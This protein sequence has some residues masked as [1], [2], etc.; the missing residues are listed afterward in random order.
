[1]V[2]F[3]R[4][5]YVYQRVPRSSHFLLDHGQPERLQAGPQENRVSKTSKTGVAA[6]DAMAVVIGSEAGA[7]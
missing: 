7:F 6:M 5:L 2:I 3:H 1:M 4:F